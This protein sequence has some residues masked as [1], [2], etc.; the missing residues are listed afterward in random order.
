M[1]CDTASS[2]EFGSNDDKKFLW[3]SAQCQF[4]LSWCAVFDMF[5]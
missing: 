2:L 1:L 5:S 3:V 4:N